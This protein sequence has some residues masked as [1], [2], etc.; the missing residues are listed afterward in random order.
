MVASSFHHTRH[1]YRPPALSTNSDL[2]HGAIGKNGRGTQSRAHRLARLGAGKGRESPAVN[3]P[4]VQ[5]VAIASGRWTPECDKEEVAPFTKE[6]TAEA[7][8]ALIKPLALQPTDR[9]EGE[10]WSMMDCSSTSDWGVVG[11]DTG[12]CFLFLYNENR[13]SECEVRESTELPSLPRCSSQMSLLADD[14]Q[15]TTFRCQTVV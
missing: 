11:C 15:C 3:K 14:L 13:A 1:T 9:A 7:P 10:G 2:R 4:T 12:S 5:L 8:A 6:P